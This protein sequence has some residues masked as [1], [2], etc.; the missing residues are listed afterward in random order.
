MQLSKRRK[1]RIRYKLKVQRRKLY[2]AL[3]QIVKVLIEN[4]GNGG[5]YYAVIHPLTYQILEGEHE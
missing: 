2:S 4:R 3:N 5:D 1:R